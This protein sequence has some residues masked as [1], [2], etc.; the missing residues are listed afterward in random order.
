VRVRPTEGG[1][2]VNAGL[3]WVIIV[4]MVCATCCYIAWLDARGR[5]P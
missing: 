3:C 1:I 5:K 4:G 2:E